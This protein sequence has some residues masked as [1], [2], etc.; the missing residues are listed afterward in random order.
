MKRDLNI[1]KN[2]KR[3]INLNTKVVK[4][5]KKYTRKDKHKMNFKNFVSEES[6]P[7]VNSNI[8]NTNEAVNSKYAEAL[9]SF[10]LSDDNIINCGISNDGTLYVDYLR[11]HDI[12]KADISA[13][14]AL[15]KKLKI[16][17]LAKITT[18]VSNRV[19]VK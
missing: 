8:D 19:V 13:V 12:T 4:D 10:Q 16:K 2:Y 17:G 1:I 9:K 11:K 6:K 14:Q 18:D 5:K 15:A 7:A 3:E